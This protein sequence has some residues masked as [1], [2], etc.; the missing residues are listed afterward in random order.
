MRAVIQRVTEASV[1][2]DGKVVGRIGPG[3]VVL[4]GVGEN[5]S[6]KEV[7][8]VAEKISGL[9]IFEDSSGRMNLSIEDTGGEILAISQFTLYGDT[10][11]GRRPSYVRAAGGDSARRF[12]ELFITKLTE[13]GIPV[14]T[15]VFGAHMDVS[16]V[17][18]GPVTLLV[19]SSKDF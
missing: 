7:A 18:C 3:M 6:E 5:D 14:E 13:R 15:G 9:R 17:N 19:D 2:V 16:M 12:Y 10:R 4:L 8:Y 11:K 1:S